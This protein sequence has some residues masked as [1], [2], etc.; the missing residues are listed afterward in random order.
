MG[1]ADC[2]FHGSC[3]NKQCKCEPNFMDAQCNVCSACTNFR[4]KSAENDGDSFLTSKL[5]DNMLRLDRADGS[6]FESY[7][8]PV[9]FYGSIDATTGTNIVSSDPLVILLFSGSDYWIWEIDVE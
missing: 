5:P 9:Y 2:T 8:R 6:P 7:Q 4:F 1:V 3:E